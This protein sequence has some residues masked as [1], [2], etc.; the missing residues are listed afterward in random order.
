[1]YSLRYTHV[2]LVVHCLS[3]V[4]VSGA[5]SYSVSMH[6]ARVVQVLSLVGVAAKDSKCLVKSH[7]L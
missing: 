6:T 5:L 7:T 4:V 3:V 1:M 2:V